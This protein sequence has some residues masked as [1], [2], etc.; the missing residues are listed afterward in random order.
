[1]LS[2]TNK[3]VKKYSEFFQSPN[4]NIECAK[5][6]NDILENMFKE[7]IKENIKLRISQIKEKYGS[8]RVYIEFPGSME[9]YSKAEKIIHKAE[10]DSFK[11][12]ELCGK[13]AKVQNIKGWYSCICV[14]CRMI[15][16]LKGN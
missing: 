9:D 8:L 3:L 11:T 7:F 13:E 4:F 10:S 5:G 15:E 12:C 14:R 6:W 2:T 16:K 1:M